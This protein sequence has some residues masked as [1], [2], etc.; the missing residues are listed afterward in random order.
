[1]AG[2]SYCESTMQLFMDYRSDVAEQTNS[3]ADGRS[4][5]PATIIGIFNLIGGLIQQL[6]AFCNKTPP[7]P[8]PIPEELVTEGVSSK[9]WKMASQSKWGAE[10]AWIANKSHYNKA[11][12]NRMAA[13]IAEENGTKKKLERPAAI[14]ALNAARE[15]DVAVLAR[16]A[17]DA[18]H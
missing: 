18:G 15:N 13:K 7:E 3:H 1:M 4:F 11:A 9:A 10:Q 2:R 12:V 16:A 17:R 6:A 14:A 8:D 5:D